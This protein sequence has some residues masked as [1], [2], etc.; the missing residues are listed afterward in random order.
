M[1]DRQSWHA[2]ALQLHRVPLH[3]LFIPRIQMPIPTAI[4]HCYNSV[5]SCCF[6]RPGALSD[7]NPSLQNLGK[8]LSGGA[9]SSLFT[10]GFLCFNRTESPEADPS[11]V[12]TRFY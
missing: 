4:P 1:E 9:P 12:K 5:A 3:S 10:T 11:D 7:L 8:E 2:G 6:R